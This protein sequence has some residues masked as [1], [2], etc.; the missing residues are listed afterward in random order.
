MVC[1]DCKEESDIVGK[2]SRAYGFHNTDPNDLVNFL[3]EHENHTLRYVDEH[4]NEH[5][6]VVQK[7]N[8]SV[9]HPYRICYCC[10]QPLVELDGK[11]A[12]VYDGVSKDDLEFMLK[13]TQKAMHDL[14]FNTCYGGMRPLSE[15]AAEIEARIKAIEEHLKR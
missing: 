1:T 14:L 11:W 13:D 5:D 3:F 12:C 7:Y 8:G 15:I 4:S 6:D 10:D 2:N 9:A